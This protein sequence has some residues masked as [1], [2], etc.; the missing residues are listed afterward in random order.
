MVGFSIGLGIV[1]VFGIA[2]LA[3][4]ASRDHAIVDNS[5]DY[6]KLFD[7]GVTQRRKK[8]RI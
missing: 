8:N 6:S 3:I 1:I 4:D 7:E 5:S 2:A